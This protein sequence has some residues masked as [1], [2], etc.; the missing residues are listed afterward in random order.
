M[1]TLIQRSPS[2]YACNDPIQ[3]A[4]WLA[5]Q[6]YR[7]EDPRNQHEYLR[8][9][10]AQGLIVIYH[11]GSVIIQGGDLETPRQLFQSLIAEQATLSF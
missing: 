4:V 3:L 2:S 5:E 11:S 1:L 10:R 6:R 7:A 9:R 8:L